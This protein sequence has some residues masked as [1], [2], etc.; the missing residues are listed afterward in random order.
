MT[1]RILLSLS[2]GKKNKNNQIYTQKHMPLGFTTER[3]KNAFVS[4]YA[5]N[6]ISYNLKL[7]QI[8]WPKK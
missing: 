3:Q 1:T 5:W 4:I 7:Y 8:F 2:K 6:L